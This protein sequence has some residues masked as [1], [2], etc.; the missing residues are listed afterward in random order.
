MAPT[1]D[2]P[3]GAPVQHAARQPTWPLLSDEGAFQEAFHAALWTFDEAWASATEA[4][5]QVSEPSYSLHFEP[6]YLQASTHPIR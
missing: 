5:G 6:F 3:P 1:P 4:K 2:T